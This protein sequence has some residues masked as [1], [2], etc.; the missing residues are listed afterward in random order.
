[1]AKNIVLLSD[2]T[3]Q[4]GGVGFATNVWF[5]N[6]ALPR[7]DEQF[8]CYDDGVGSQKLLL[9]RVIGGA[10]GVGLARNVRH[11]YSF[12]VRTWEPGAKIYLFGFSRGAFTVRLLAG[13]IARCGVIDLKKMESEK[14][15][16]KSVRASYCAF[17][18]SQFFPGVAGKFKEQF[19]VIDKTTG[20][21][22][23]PIRFVGVWDTVDAVG[24]PFD[25]MRDAFDQIQ[26]YS[27]RDNVLSPSVD[28]G[29][30]AVAID[31]ARRTFAPVMWDERLET[32][33]RIQQV[34]FSGVHSNVGGG[35]P[36]RQMAMLSLTWMMREAIDKGLRVETTKL[37]EYDRAADIY[38]RLYDSRAGLSA[39]YRHQPR[40]MNEIGPEYTYQDTQVHHSVF[41][42]IKNAFDGYSPHNLPDRCAVV[43][44]FGGTVSLPEDSR[45]EMNLAKGIVWWRR[46]LL[47]MLWAIS[48]AVLL[49]PWFAPYE[50]APSPM[51]TAAAD[52]IVTVSEWALPDVA[53]KWKSA[54]RN[55]PWL[56][57][58]AV[59]T[60]LGLVWARWY[61]KNAAVELANAG[62][63]HLYPQHRT[64]SS[65]EP[66]W[67]GAGDRIRVARW[68]EHSTSL[69][70]LAQML[71][72]FVVGLLSLFLFIPLKFSTWAH[73]R[74][75]LGGK[76]FEDVR[77]GT[78]PAEL[79]LGEE[80]TL[81]FL[82]RDYKR[83]TGI[84]VKAGEAYRIR[85]EQFAG[86]RDGSYPASPIGLD[87]SESA[88]RMDK[89]FWLFK[90][91]PSVRLMT[92]MARVQRPIMSW[93]R[94]AST[95][96]AIGEDGT[97]I[98]EKDGELT[99]YVNDAM[100]VNIPILRGVLFG[101]REMFYRNNRGIASI[102]ISRS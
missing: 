48:L 63:F 10:V 20:S 79:G 16:E 36:K 77:K 66:K 69:S 8:V 93:F 6:E 65:Q 82:P 24:V 99:L 85:V 70:N 18:T 61:I 74:W 96:V 49:V 64:P 68:A 102:R 40:D 101:I 59:L 37:E 55:H 73:R 87:E 72:S 17:R 47:G 81:I 12:L 29:R 23:V 86:W 98:P 15:L 44:G 56:T 94:V 32:D 30:H 31:E 28:Y 90:R 41:K 88:D 9:S 42:R 83:L 71:G 100:L 84:Q 25:E 19:G 26:R 89:M 53:E 67:F 45:R 11:L 60:L 34:W 95:T 38:G 91:H 21:T 13:L 27:F 35:Y 80:Q 51:V 39:Y 43:G 76:R 22:D 58:G 75:C 52:S 3:G 1:M 5:L 54:L 2:G 7:D 62:W 50:P 92:L 46:P 78:K 14:G 4:R 57:L 97:I 33:N